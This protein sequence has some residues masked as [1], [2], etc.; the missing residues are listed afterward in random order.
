MNDRLYIGVD[1]GSTTVKVVV[2]DANLSVVHSS[3]RRHQSDTLRTVDALLR[4]LAKR[5]GDRPAVLRITGSGGLRLSEKAGIR[6]VQ[7]VAAVR[8]AVEALAPRTNVVIELG[9]E[10]AKIVYLDGAIEER[11][12]GSCA[13]G[14]GAFIDQMATLLQTDAAGI[15]ALAADAAAIYPIAARCG[16]FAKTDIQP[17]LNEG[18]RREDIAASVLQ[19]V[20][21]QTISG[22]ACGRPIRGNVLFLGGPLNYLPQLRVRFR[23]TL[24]LAEDAAVCP[25]DAHLFVGVGAALSSVLDEPTDLRALIRRLDELALTAAE[26][27]GMLPRLFESG[28]DR[29]AF[30]ARHATAHV[31]RTALDGYRGAAY[32]GID[33]GSTTFKLAL[34]GDEGQI[35]HSHYGSNNGDIVGSAAAAL[36]ELYREL[37]TGVV[38]RSSVVTGY[39]ESLLQAAL[40]VDRGEIETIAHARAA[41]EFAPDVDFILDIGGQDM[42]CLHL[43]GGVIDRIMLNEACSSGCGSFIQTFATTLGLTVEEFVAEALSAERPV[44]L[45]SR[46]TVFM[47]SRVRQAQNEGATVADIAAGLCYSVVKNALYKVIRINDPSQ[48]GKRIVVQGGTFAN[49]AILRA[50]EQLTGREVVRPDVS[51]LMGAWGAALLAR[52][53]C[54]G[55]NASAASTLISAADLASLTIDQ[56]TARCHGCSNS[57]RLTVTR[58]DGTRTFVSGNRCERGAGGGAKQGAA[59]ADSP[60]A[61]PNLFDYKYRRLF[62]YKP[63]SPEQAPLG[64]IGIPRALNTYENYPFWFTL[65]TQLGFSVMLSEGSTSETYRTGIE[66]MP[67]ESVCYPAKLSHGHIENLISRGARR[68]FMPCVREERRE[69]ERA[70]NCFNCPV[71]QSYSE[72]V[73]LNTERLTH[74]GIDFRNPFIPYQDRHAL[75]RRLAE[76]LAD[77]GVTRQAAEQAV[78][79]AWAEDEAFKADVRAEGKRALEW[80]ERTSGRGIVLAGRPYHL[81]PEI[82]HAIPQMISRLGLAVL[83]EDSVAEPTLLP[84]PIRVFDQWMFHSRL[85][86]AAAFVATQ[87]RLEFVQLNSFGCGLDALTID[88]AGEILTSAGKIHTVLKIDE[89]SNV[90][91]ARIRIRSLLAALN[92]L[93][94][95]P[96]S[97]LDAPKPRVTYTTDMRDEGWTILAPQMAPI[98]F[99]LL[100]PVFRAAGYNVK[101]LEDAGPGAVEEGLRHVNNDSCYPSIMT[102]GQIIEALK[103]DEYDL[104]RT[105]VMITQTGGICRATNYLALLRKALADADLEHVPV[106]SLSPVSTGEESPGFRIPPDMLARGIAAIVCGDTLSRCLYR[107]RPYERDAGSAEAL[108]ATWTERGQELFGGRFTILRYARLLRGMVADFDALP[109]EGDRRPRVGVVGEI[110]VKYHPDANNHLVDAIEAEG[111]EAIVGDMI[112]FILY[113]VAGEYIRRRECAQSWG[114]WAIG[115]LGVAA[116]SLIQLPARIALKASKR[117]DAPERIAHVL[118]LARSVISPCNS[119]GEG[120]LLTGEMRAYMAAGVPNIVC[121]QPFACLPN[122]VVGRG[123]I[124]EIRRLHPEANIVAVD[125][126]PG[127]SETNQINRLRL[128]LTTAKE[129]HGAGM[130]SVLSRIEEMASGGAKLRAE[131]DDQQ[132]ECA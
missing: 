33:A 38:I 95:T 123:V 2:L 44:D 8:T 98:H 118:R 74:E 62:D 64:V 72:V 20:V 30:V 1:V 68:I 105:A 10:D 6:F 128:M 27:V 104:A 85:Y 15:D 43:K 23:E 18:A 36:G 11:M 53:R 92:E 17:L 73:K 84:R 57:C 102:V 103:S 112:A 58:F 99:A 97:A 19:S 16:V 5:V 75:A 70:D 117:F 94:Q 93:E 132:D 40:C 122:H 88:Q 83:T 69:D 110:L 111:C 37:P 116:I 63:L 126:D 41:R 115:R 9:G 131:D 50:F 3:Y 78:Q 119:M 24:G 42:K 91:A 39:G 46:C 28:D 22:L 71:V 14:T 86:A 109:I 87:R 66:S 13:G 65:F 29:A 47:N 48:L 25:E 113:S 61:P 90:A 130:P 60:D 59:P 96:P 51:A 100:G 106:I 108:A 127:A 77:W 101:I 21:T 52:D 45:G 81:D 35:L 107:T 114:R 125:Y 49:D 55:A 79:L 67:S 121:V 76:E 31:E 4:E 7:E 129:R 56:R 120:W 89:I 124:K 32:L 34:I 54:G 26:P 12:N 82:N 80:I